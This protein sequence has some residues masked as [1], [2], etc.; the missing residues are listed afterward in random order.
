M[1]PALVPCSAYSYPGGGGMARLLRPRA[2]LGVARPPP[3]GPALA[4]WL[5]AL[6]GRHKGSGGSGGGASYV[7][8][9][10][11]SSAASAQVPVAIALQSVN[12]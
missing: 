2:W 8:A 11:S 5:C 4:S 6:W 3:G 9:S 10:N 12:T 7:M 1:F